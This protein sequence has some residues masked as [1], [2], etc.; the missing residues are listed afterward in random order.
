MRAQI[1]FVIV[2]IFMIW[3]PFL[4]LWI[5]SVF[6]FHFLHA[7]FALFLYSNVWLK[8]LVYEST[9][10]CFFRIELV[11]FRTKL[12]FGC[13]VHSKI[14]WLQKTVSNGATADVSIQCGSRFCCGLFL[15]S[16][17]FGFK[18]DCMLER[19]ITGTFT[20]TLRLHFVQ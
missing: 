2:V 18:I 9:W 16:T 14:Q 15:I 17:I 20:P 5:S 6:F 1:D 13:C 3:Q 19:I 8:N 4:C 7:P 12:V 10:M 11:M